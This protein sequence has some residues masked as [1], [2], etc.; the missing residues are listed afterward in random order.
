[1]GKYKEV[2]QISS[3]SKQTGGLEAHDNE[4]IC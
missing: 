4:D 3:A 1:M 2:K